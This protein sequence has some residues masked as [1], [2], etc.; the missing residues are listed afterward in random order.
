MSN[1]TDRR[2]ADRLARKLAFQEAR[3]KPA[4][5]A[6]FFTTPAAEP[7]PEPVHFSEEPQISEA[8]LAAN[9]ANAQF[10]SGPVTAAGRAKSSMN[11][12]KHGLTGKTV[13]LPHEDATEYQS[14]L[15]DSIEIHQPATDEELRLV[16]SVLD[17]EWR[18][19]RVM[20]LES[21]VYLKGSIEF[22][23]KFED[24][25]PV[26]RQ[27][28]INAETYLK[29]EKP[30]RNLNIQE[31]RLRRT[32]EKDKAELQ[33]LQTLRKREELAAIQA[34][35]SQKPAT[36]PQPQPTNGFEFSDSSNSQ[37]V[38]PNHSATGH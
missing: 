25:S 12:L 5:T 6:E 8:Q 13:V 33:R 9:R 32:M 38:T 23:D 19:N 17:C 7:E 34:Q 15:T 18:L 28:L 14:R 16:R 21:G 2:E 36:R 27:H 31:A 37:P 30:I 29:Y 10:S 11:A 20:Q 26:E 22:K 1:R 24:R 4:Q 3:N 35:K